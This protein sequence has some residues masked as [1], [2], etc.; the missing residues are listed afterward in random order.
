MAVSEFTEV[1]T[2]I[3][4]A[5]SDPIHQAQCDYVAYYSDKDVRFFKTFSSKKITVA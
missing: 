2:G 3:G 5:H 4:E 1:K